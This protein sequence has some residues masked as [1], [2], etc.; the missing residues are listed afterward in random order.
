[1]GYA[2]LSYM[3]PLFG[4]ANSLLGQDGDQMAFGL[5]QVEAGSSLGLDD[6]DMGGYPASHV[7]AHAI[8]AA[9]DHALTL[10]AVCESGAITN[11]AP[12][13]LVRG[14]LE[15]ASLAV[16]ML[17]PPKRVVRQERAF[18]VWH[19]D[20][21]ERGKWEAD[22]SRRPPRRQARS[23]VE[24]GTQIRELAQARGLSLKQ[25]NVHLSYADVVAE[26]GESVGRDRG[27]S[28]A[29]WRECSGFAHGRTWPLLTRSSP[30]GVEEIPDGFALAMTF[31][32]E[33][34]REATELATAIFAAA[35]DRYAAAAA[36]DLEATI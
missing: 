15:P 21:G 2:D 12:W 24:R 34:H 18:R 13:T 11:A 5:G 23:A 4:L 17:K 36:A 8:G 33:F 32:E 6:R 14:I 30:S 19:A 3:G 7:V 22:I 28:T 25:I 16:W 35:L 10:Q 27:R 29:L 31:A 20:M 9:V 1:M 26:A